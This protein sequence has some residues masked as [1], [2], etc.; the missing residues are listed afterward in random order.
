MAN[1]QHSGLT[2]PNLHEPKGISSA[3]NNQLYLS[4]GSGSGTWTNA[5]RFPGT[6]WGRY[7]N[8]TYVGTNALA[9]ST[10]EVLVPFTT[11]DNETQLPIT[12]TGTTT[13]LLDLSTEVLKFVATGD[14]HSVQLSFKIYST[15][16]SPARVDLRLYGSPD[17]VTNVLLAEKTVSI[18]KG[19]DQIISEVSLFNVS[20]DM[21]SNGAK[22]Y[23]AT[24]TGTINIIDISLISARVHKAR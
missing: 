2:D 21:V 18:T 11:A 22:I 15:S 8:T 9:V 20:S 12:L 14:M 16:G 7:T 6:G 13:S 19:T 17:G 10:T 4:N 3:A 24:N 1:V 5:S 23:L